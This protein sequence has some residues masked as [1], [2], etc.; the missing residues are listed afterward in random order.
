MPRGSLPRPGCRRVRVTRGLDDSTVGVSAAARGEPMGVAPGTL[1]RFA[2]LARRSRTCRGG[3]RPALAALR[4]VA[5]RAAAGGRYPSVR[6]D[7][8]ADR[9]LGIPVPLGARGG[10]GSRHSLLRLLEWEWFAARAAIQSRRRDSHAAAA[11]DILAA[12][13]VVSATSLARSSISPSRAPRHCSTP[14][15]RAALRSKSPIAQSGASSGSSTWRHYARQ[16][17]HPAA[18]RGEAGAGRWD[19]CSRGLRCRCAVS[20]TARGR[21]A[22]AHA[23]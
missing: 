2:G 1:D 10:G 14:L 22:E 8:T 16:Q 20:G 11:V 4:A 6:G 15:S 9:A 19:R 12:A 21:A 5:R 13:P 18:R 17:H 3:D 7:A 23:A